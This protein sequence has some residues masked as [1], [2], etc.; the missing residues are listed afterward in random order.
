MTSRT[1]SVLGLLL[2]YPNKRYIFLIE[3]ISMFMRDNKM[4]IYYNLTIMLMS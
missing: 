2:E 4:T 1:I 3:I